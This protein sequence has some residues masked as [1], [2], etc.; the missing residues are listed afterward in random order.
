MDSSILGQANIMAAANM[1]TDM[2]FPKRLGVLTC[3]GLEAI[4]AAEEGGGKN[5]PKS[6]EAWNPMN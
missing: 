1:E 3:G 2:V 6:L 5:L 4:C